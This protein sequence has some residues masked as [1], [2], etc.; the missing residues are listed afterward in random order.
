MPSTPWYVLDTLAAAYAEV[1]D[2]DEAKR[3]QTETIGAA[4]PEERE[5]CRVA[6]R[7]YENKQPRRDSKNERFA[8][9]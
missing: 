5:E 3:L 6:L 2:F 7:L 1:G 4:P 9:D 8:D